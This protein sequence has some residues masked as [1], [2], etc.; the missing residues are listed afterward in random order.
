MEKHGIKKSQKTFE[1]N[2][3]FKKK[4]EKCFIIWL[5]AKRKSIYFWIGTELEIRIKIK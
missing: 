4:I 1:N 3:L 5:V 2:S